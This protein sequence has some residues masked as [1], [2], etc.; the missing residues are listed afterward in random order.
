MKKTTLLPIALGLAL[1]ACQTMPK[2]EPIH[3]PTNP[4]PEDAAKAKVKYYGSII[5]LRPEKEKEYRELHANVWP[6]VRAA[7]AKATGGTN[8]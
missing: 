6:D 4:T 5:E 3:G 2:T 7:I 1:S 8:E